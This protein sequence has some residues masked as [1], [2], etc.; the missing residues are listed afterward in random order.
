[1]G[2]GRESRAG[3]AAKLCAAAAAFAKGWHDFVGVV[4][5]LER[6]AYI[7]DD[8]GLPENYEVKDVPEDM[9][10][11]VEKY[12]TELVETA[13]EQVRCGTSQSGLVMRPHDESW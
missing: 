7:W 5:L 4:D 10:A 2:A 1:M 13:I 12:R 11:D 8:T 6:K 9:K 3:N